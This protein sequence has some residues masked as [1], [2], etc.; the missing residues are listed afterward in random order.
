L[1]DSGKPAHCQLTARTLRWR[2][3]FRR[4]PVGLTL[5]AGSALCV[6]AL[7]GQAAG[8]PKGT[9]AAE[10][11]AVIAGAAGGEPEPEPAPEPPPEPEIDAATAAEYLEIIPEMETKDLVA[12]LAEIGETTHYDD[13]TNC[14]S[15]TP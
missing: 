11:A 10:A 12:A 7:E 6:S 8:S 4:W 5:L 1:L 15:L 13:G 14:A 3:P 9:G 2:S